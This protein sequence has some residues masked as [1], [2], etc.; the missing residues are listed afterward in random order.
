MLGWSIFFINFLNV[1]KSS[2][3]QTTWHSP[4]EDVHRSPKFSCQ[5]IRA[6]QN[7]SFL[8]APV[9]KTLPTRGLEMVFLLLRA[10]SPRLPLSQRACPSGLAFRTNPAFSLSSWDEL[11]T[12]ED[13]NWNKLCGKDLE[14]CSLHS[15][16]LLGAV[17]RSGMYYAVFGLKV[18]EQ[19]PFGLLIRIFKG[20]IG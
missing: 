8:L 17:F 11:L 5:S 9:V 16:F 19:L 13:D 12:R 3:Q 10:Q 18:N 1:V 4:W 7:S 20:I 6:G 15:I 2:W 14:P